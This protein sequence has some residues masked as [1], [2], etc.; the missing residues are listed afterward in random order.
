MRSP[1][2][3]LLFSLILL[4][5][6]ALHAQSGFEQVRQSLSQTQYA[7]AAKELQRMV[8]E[9]GPSLKKPDPREEKT[10]RGAVDTARE[11]LKKGPPAYRNAARQILC[12]SR[13]YFP[14]E[15]PGTEQ[16]LRV[17]GAVQRPELIGKPL[18]RYPPE[19]RRAGMQGTVILEVI[20]DQEGCV[21]HPRILKG[22]PMGIDGA[23][24][25]AVRSWTY[26]PAT[27]EGRHVPVYYV[28]TVPFALKDRELP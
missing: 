13:A 14:E 5:G 2:C 23:A 24:L 9:G 10:L 27:L 8:L 4:A 3:G 12:L 21:R 19:A 18:R 25:I 7:E 15:L 11:I 1:D 20:I 16:A 22:V 28:L 26:Q 6:P 17:G